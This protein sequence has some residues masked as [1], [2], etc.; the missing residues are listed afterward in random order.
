MKSDIPKNHDVSL[1]MLLR[2]FRVCM[3]H[4][5]PRYTARQAS[6]NYGIL[7]RDCGVSAVSA[8]KTTRF[9]IG[10]CY[11]TI[12]IRVGVVFGSGKSLETS[13]KF[14]LAG[15]TTRIANRPKLIRR[16]PAEFNT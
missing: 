1:L 9:F 10:A 15:D 16:P 5:Q 2:F 14:V 6:C 12:I 7:E 3:N 4:Q 8:A 13:V 11:H